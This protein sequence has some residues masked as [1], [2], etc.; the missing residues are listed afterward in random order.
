[1]YGSEG[2]TLA[3]SVWLDSTPLVENFELS[4]GASA[5][6]ANFTLA[7][8]GLDPSTD[9]RSIS[10]SATHGDQEYTDSAELVYLPENPYNGS[11]VKIDRRSGYLQVQ[12]EAGEAWETVLPFGFYDVSL[13]HIPAASC[14]R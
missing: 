1:M 3:V 13:L 2:D 4:L 10:C 9:P 11:S 14:T 5:A 7:S 12:Y 6:T 8:L